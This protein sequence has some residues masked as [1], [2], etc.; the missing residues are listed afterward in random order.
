MSKGKALTYKE[1]EQIINDYLQALRMVHGDNRAG[2]TEVT[3]RKGWFNVRHPWFNADTP[4]VPYRPQELKELTR[5]LL[6][7][8]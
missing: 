1:I 3:Y 8:K 5:E 4:S 7:Q 2:Q 6:M